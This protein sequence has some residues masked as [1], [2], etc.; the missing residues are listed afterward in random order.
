M[1]AADVTGYGA[2]SRPTPTAD[3]KAH[4]KRSMAAEEVAAMATLGFEQFAV[5]G[6]DRGGRV[7]YRM[8]LDHPGR[9]EQLTVYDV[10]PEREV[11]RREADFARACSTS[12][13]STHPGSPPGGPSMTHD[14]AAPPDPAELVDDLAG[15]LHR[16]EIQHESSSIPGREI[17][18]VLT[19]IPCGVESGWHIHPG[20]EVGFIVAGT[21]QMSIADRPT[22]TLHA[23]DGFLIPPR[24]AH[25][26]L[27]LGPET[28]R[29]LSTYLVETGQPLATFVDA[30]PPT[31]NPPPDPTPPAPGADHAIA[32]QTDHRARAWCVRRIRQ[33]ERGHRR[34]LGDGY[35]VIA[36]ANPLRGVLFDAATSAAS[37][38]GSTAASF[39]SGTRTAAWSTPTPRHSRVTA[40]VYVGGFAP[41]LGESA[42]DLS[43]A[44]PAARWPRPSEAVTLPDGGNDLYIRQDAY[45]RQF[46]ADSPP[47]TP[48][49]WPSPSDPSSMP[50]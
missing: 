43:A 14:P 20:E 47:P 3:H 13:R 45:H 37:S 40:L 22:L 16:T 21:V 26:T 1:V 39:S 15:K 9:I 34:L 23:G 38:T 41:D 29:M 36:V 12:S 7:G 25:N 6:H 32:H 10:V 35:P 4:S 30:P 24:V 17:V 42:A 18:Q 27:D 19:E 50:R 8:A 44:S 33:L 48:R 31:P 11:W 5:A 2:S 28:G 49:R 46:A